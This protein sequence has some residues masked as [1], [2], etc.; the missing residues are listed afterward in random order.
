MF[1][2][3]LKNGTTIEYLMF[4]SLLIAMDCRLAAADV[5]A[6]L[7]ARD[8]NLVIVYQA[9]P[10]VSDTFSN[11]FVGEYVEFGLA[12]LLQAGCGLSKIIVQVA[13]VNHQLRGSFRQAAQQF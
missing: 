13:R 1:S 8:A 10:L 6:V 11:G 4:V 9:N 7:S 2:C 12:R 5:S 3:S